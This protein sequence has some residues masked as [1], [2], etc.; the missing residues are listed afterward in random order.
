[1]SSQQIYWNYLDS[2]SPTQNKTVA[3]LGWYAK[4][5]AVPKTV[6]PV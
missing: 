1:V 3:V 4:P 2:S 5:W 6:G